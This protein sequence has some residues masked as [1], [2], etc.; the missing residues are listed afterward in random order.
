[1]E[2]L[3]NLAFAALFS[4]GLFWWLVL[5]PEKLRNFVN[6][7][8]MTVLVFVLELLEFLVNITKVLTLLLHFLGRIGTLLV[9]CIALFLAINES[10]IIYGSTIAVQSEYYQAW[11]DLLSKPYAWAALAA[12][13]ASTSAINQI[14][15]YEMEFDKHLQTQK[16][17]YKKELSK[18]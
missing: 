18:N 2:V 13:V 1:M 16:S 5:A 6:N 17:K 15:K 8:L 12:I 7:L 9:L 4:F 11:L 14:L 10:L 3:K